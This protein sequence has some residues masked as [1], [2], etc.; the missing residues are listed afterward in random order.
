MLG[1]MLG[2]PAWLALVSDL[3]PAGATGRIMGLVATAQGAGAFLGPLAGG[4]LW[5]VNL[6]SPFY[7]AAALLTLSAVVALLLLQRTQSSSSS[8]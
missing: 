2:L 6:R 7:L 5:D 3:A 4:Y 8:A 1:F